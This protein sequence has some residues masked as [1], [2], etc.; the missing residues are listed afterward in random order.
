MGV[1]LSSRSTI[2]QIDS[3]RA[4]LLSDWGPAPVREDR[5]RRHHSAEGRERQVLL[6]ARVPAPVKI[7]QQREQRSTGQC[8]FQEYIRT[9][10]RQQPAQHLQT[11]E[12][13]FHLRLL[14]PWQPEI[15]ALTVWSNAGARNRQLADPSMPGAADRLVVVD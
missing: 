7:E 5:G 14:V 13:D 9:E 10:P 6:D 1:A 12:E 4:S 11:D 15:R 2:C 8:D 3:G